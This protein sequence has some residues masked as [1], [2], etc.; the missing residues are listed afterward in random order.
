[1]QLHYTGKNIEITPAL[2]A[3]TDE[4]FAHL[5]NKF[6]GITNVYIVFAV[7]R[8]NQMAEAT[9]HIHGKEINATAT[10][11]DMYHSIDAMIDKLS[12]QLAKHKEKLTD[13]H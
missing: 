6:Q 3:H 9:I 12:T 2:K 13:H 11:N 1:M 10:T 8:N 5:N 7:E 4:K